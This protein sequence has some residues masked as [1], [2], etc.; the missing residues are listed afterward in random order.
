MDFK[1]MC[2]VLICLLQENLQLNKQKL[3]HCV[4]HVPSTNE[5]NKDNIHNTTLGCSIIYNL[6]K[7][8][9]VLI[10][11]SKKGKDGAIIN[12]NIQIVVIFLFALKNS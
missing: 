4:K 9:K 2:V 12:A 10:G 6:V 7:T 8:S 1:R 3:H 11:C 5:N